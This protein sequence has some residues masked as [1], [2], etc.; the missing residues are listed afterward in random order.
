LPPDAPPDIYQGWVVVSSGDDF[1]IP[2]RLVA[3]TP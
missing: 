3:V 2:I 1:R